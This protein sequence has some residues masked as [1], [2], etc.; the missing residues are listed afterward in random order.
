MAAL[1]LTIDTKECNSQI[2]TQNP[3]IMF[4]CHKAY[5]QQKTKPWWSIGKANQTRESTGEEPVRSAS[6]SRDGEQNSQPKAYIK[7]A[8]ANYDIGHFKFG[9]VYYNCNSEKVGAFWKIKINQKQVIW[10]VHSPSTIL[11]T[12]GTNYLTKIWKLQQSNS[13]R[14]GQLRTNNDATNCNDARQVS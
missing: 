7:L 8:L 12:K 4:V 9:Q 10:Q 6:K 13:W 3:L 14:K 2:R 5:F 11:K 1:K